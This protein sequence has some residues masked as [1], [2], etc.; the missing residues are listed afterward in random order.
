MNKAKHKANQDSKNWKQIK[1][2]ES[3]TSSGTICPAIDQE[4]SISMAQLKI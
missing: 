4:S 2:V 1:Q 3:S